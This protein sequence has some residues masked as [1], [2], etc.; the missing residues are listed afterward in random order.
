VQ[1]GVVGAGGT[2]KRTAREAV[3]QA[4]ATLERARDALA[5]SKGRRSSRRSLAGQA[6][7]TSPEGEGS[8]PAERRARGVVKRARERAQ[9]EN[10]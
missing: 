2:W 10:Q 1:R 8:P 3:A 5:E 6:M 7:R 9:G 4:A